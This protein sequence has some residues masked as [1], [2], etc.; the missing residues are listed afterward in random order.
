MTKVK[1]GIIGAG[2][3]GQIAFI[4][5]FYKNKKCQIYGLAEARQNFREKVAKKF[6]IKKLT[7][8]LIRT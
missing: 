2:F 8:L 1:L 6:K 5:N 4:Q 7:V 3:N